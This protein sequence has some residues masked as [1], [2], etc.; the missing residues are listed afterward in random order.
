MK[1]CID[2]GHGMSNRKLG[3]YDP[4]ATH[5]ENGTTYEEATIALRYGLTLKDILRARGIETFM[6]RDDADDNA[7]VGM[8]ARNARAV[9]CD[10]FISFHLNDAEAD[11]AN[12]LEILYGNANSAELAQDLL[13]VLLRTTR[14]KN[15][16]TVL[17]PDLAVLK[18]RGPAALIE[19]GFIAND[20]DREK[21]LDPAMRQLICRDVADVVTQH[22][23]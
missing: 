21:V 2:P 3:T 23:L 13:S 10:A 8:R 1:I 6:T 4:G 14:F 18:F 16:G 7:P 5:T 17:R 15:R 22:L 12:G 11:Q 20:G 9:G 19:L